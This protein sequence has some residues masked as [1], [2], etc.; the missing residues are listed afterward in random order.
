[1]S[2]TRDVEVSGGVLDTYMVS[3]VIGV[4]GGRVPG[5]GK[6]KREDSEIISCI[7]IGRRRLKS[8]RRSQAPLPWCGH[9]G[10]HMPAM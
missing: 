6:K 4:S 2:Q 7:G 3:L 1:M 5:E 8:Y 10:V 9:C